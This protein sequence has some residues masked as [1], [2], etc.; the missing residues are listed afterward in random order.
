MEINLDGNN[1]IVEIIRKNNKNIYFRF[2]EDGHLY[3]TCN[4]FVSIKNIQNILT[5]NKKAI[6]RMYNT[7]QKQLQ[8]NLQFYYLGFPY[9]KVYDEN[10][11]RPFISESFIYFK[12]ESSEKKW[13]KEQCLTIFNNRI[14]EC[15]KKFSNIPHFALKI[16]A[17]KTRWGVNNIIKKQI[18]LNSE[19]IKKDISLIDYV[20]VHELCHFYEPN[21]SKRFWSQVEKHYPNYKEARKQLRG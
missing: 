6:L 7:N 10:I 20:I 9:T 2:K 21:H 13:L 17:M 11:K 4:R 15:L 5:E 12:N 3:V 1:I 18:T 14:N 19:L 16:R 8:E